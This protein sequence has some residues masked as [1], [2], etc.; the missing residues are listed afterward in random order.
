MDCVLTWT[1]PIINGKLTP[2]CLESINMMSKPSLP[3]TDADYE[4][5]DLDNVIADTYDFMDDEEKILV[6]D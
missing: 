3:T 5:I 2:M 6:V 4:M 1:Y